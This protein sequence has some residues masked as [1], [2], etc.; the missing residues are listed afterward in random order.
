MKKFTYEITIE[1][2][3]EDEA[4]SRMRGLSLLTEGSILPQHRNKLLPLNEEEEKLLRLYRAGSTIFNHILRRLD[5]FWEEVENE[6]QHG[7]ERN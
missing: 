6:K 7:H 2:E 5:R 4:D 3:H 1:A